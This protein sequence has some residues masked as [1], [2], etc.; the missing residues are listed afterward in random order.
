MTIETGEVGRHVGC[1]LACWTH[2]E[3][4]RQRMIKTGRS[5]VSKN[6]AAG[7]LTS[8]GECGQPSKLV[9]YRLT[10]QTR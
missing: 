5:K 9:T 7:T 1:T 10:V 3:N 2:A 4:P 8:L 6:C